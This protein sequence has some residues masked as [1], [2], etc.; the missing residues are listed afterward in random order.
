MISVVT[1]TYNRKNKVVSSIESSLGLIREGY[2]KELIVVDDASLDHTYDFLLEIYSKE[3]SSGIMKIFRLNK[4]IGVAGAKNFGVEKSEGDYVAFMDSDDVFTRNAGQDIKK[5]IIA[6]P[7]YSIYFFRCIDSISNSLIGDD[8]CS[9]SFDLRFLINGG[10]PGECLPVLR[11]S[12]ISTHAYPTK[13]RGCESLAYYKILYNHENGGYLSNIACRV[14]DSVSEDR[15]CTS[16][17]IRKRSSRMILFNF[18][19][20]SYWRFLKLRNLSKVLL[21]LVYY[22][23]KFI[24]SKI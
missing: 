6:N 14:Y 10:V 2:F 16:N 21:R 23:V 8:Q 19:V 13:L 22:S 11:K 3:I 15:L 7:S 5:T 24:E 18:Y 20:L 12:S 1:A 9:R 4:N 17:S